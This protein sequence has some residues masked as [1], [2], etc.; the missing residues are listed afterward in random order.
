LTYL[1]DTNVISETRR[2]QPDVNVMRWISNSPRSSLYLSVLT[3]G[4]IA[5][6][7]SLLAQ[8]DQMAGL[9][10]QSWLDE[11]RSQFQS[12]IVPIDAPIAEYWGQL[13]ARRSLP[14]IDGLIASTAFV[15]GFVLVTR[16]TKDFEGLG[17]QVIN[18]W[19]P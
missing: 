19:Q 8:R 7:A 11:I 10:L 17:I 16:N 18:P 4:E 14:V 1:I 9:A 5:K 12:H 13:V 6:G 15:R 3:L 2:K